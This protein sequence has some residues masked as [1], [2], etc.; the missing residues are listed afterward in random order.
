MKR[1]IGFLLF[2]ICCLVS[3]AFS[4][5]D[6]ERKAY[7]A[8]RAEERAVAEQTVQD[9]PGR[10]H[11]TADELIRLAYAYNELG[12]HRLAL[13]AVC[14]VSDEVLA[15]KHQLQMKAT[16]FHNVNFGKDKSNLVREL[17][18]IDRCLDRKYG[19]QGVWLSRKAKV[20]C[21]SSVAPV[22]I[23]IQYV[24]NED[25]IVD[26]ELYEYSFELL[27]RAFEVEPKL[28]ELVGHDSIWSQGFPLLRD[29]ARFKELIN[30][31]K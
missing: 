27:K 29:E 15:E 28:L 11:L 2:I 5:D 13:D 1:S 10:D 3:T 4:Q 22:T 30:R 14:R 24:G 25:R 7:L 31:N 20:V 17:A 23:T 26:P 19:N 6:A 16:C 12:D 18:F 21:Q 8:K 9:L